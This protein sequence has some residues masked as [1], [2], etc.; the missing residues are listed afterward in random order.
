MSK[1]R[2]LAGVVSTGAVLADGVIDAAEIGSLTLP[3]GG[4]IVGT[5]ASQTLTNKTIAFADNTLTGVQAALV[6]GTSIKTVGGQSVLGSG[7][8]SIDTATNLAGGS[9]GTIPYQSAS[10]TTQMLAA[11]TA[12]Q[13][14][15]TN[16]AAAPT[17]V[18]PGGGSWVYLSTVTAS[19][20]A[21]IDVES[22]FD[23]TYDA[24]AIIATNVSPDNAAPSF[25]ARLKLAGSYVTSGSYSMTS[26]N[27]R[28]ND[29]SNT[30]TTFNASG[31]NSILLMPSVARDT[32]VLGSG[33]NF[34]MMLQNPASTSTLK[35]I[36]TQGVG[37][38]QASSAAQAVA[39]SVSAINRGGYGALTGVRFYF[40][41]G[42]VL[43]GTF[44]L[45]GIKNS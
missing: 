22:T 21:T 29:S 24:Y 1:A 2:T 8:V 18:T 33:L 28:A 37:I 31:E 3:T 15:Q 23:S 27:T 10:G 45:Y 6:S 20:S 36:Y 9:N 7:N 43:R 5:T 40:S 38:T 12:G 39:M 16:G 17:W 4:D 35:S 14:L 32:E 34:T 26:N 13:V 42:T 19:S 25:F 41:A 44:R 11:G 30:V